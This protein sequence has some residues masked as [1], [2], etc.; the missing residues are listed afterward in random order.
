MA[1]RNCLCVERILDKKRHLDPGSREDPA[2]NLLRAYPPQSLEG[3]ESSSYLPSDH[4][5][6]FCRRRKTEPTYRKDF[7]IPGG[8]VLLMA[9]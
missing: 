1:N 7:D 4:G 3:R 6:G 9:N 5:D 2:S 8:R